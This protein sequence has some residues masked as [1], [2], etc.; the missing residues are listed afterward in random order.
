MTEP[1]LVPRTPL[2]EYTDYWLKRGMGKS[3]EY[4]NASDLLLKI[5]AELRQSAWMKAYE[6]TPKPTVEDHKIIYSGLGFYGELEKV[7]FEYLSLSY[8]EK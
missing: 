3:E 7:V 5:P 2:I 4:K 6:Q 8:G 1:F